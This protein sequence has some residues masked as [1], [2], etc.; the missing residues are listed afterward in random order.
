[1]FSFNEC[2]IFMQSSYT[3]QLYVLKLMIISNYNNCTVQL[4]R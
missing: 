1:M 3:N 4:I 2:F